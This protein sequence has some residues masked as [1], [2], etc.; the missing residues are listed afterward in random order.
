MKVA[1]YKKTAHAAYRH[2]APQGRPRALKA[3]SIESSQQQA[4]K[5]V[6]IG[7]VL[8]EHFFCWVLL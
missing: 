8:W 4:L 6:S 1:S 3:A 2:K 7:S 5:A